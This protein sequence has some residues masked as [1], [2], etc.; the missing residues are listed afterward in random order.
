MLLRRTKWHSPVRDGGNIKIKSQ[1]NYQDNT[2]QPGRPINIYPVIRGPASTAFDVAI[3]NPLP[4][5]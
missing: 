5:T 4:V 2:L 1:P 3:R